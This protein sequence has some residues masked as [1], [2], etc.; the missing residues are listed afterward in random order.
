MSIR[1]IAGAAVHDLP[2][3]VR[4]MLGHRWLEMRNR[5]ERVTID[6]RGVRCEWEFTSE[7]HLANVFPS[8][9]ARLMRAAFEQWPIVMSSEPPTTSDHPEV[10]FVIGHRGTERLP[11]LLT[12]LRSI[13]GQRSAS[14]ECIVIEQDRLP[15]IES[16]LPKWVRYRFVECETDYNRAATLNAGVAESRAPIVVLHDNDML[17]PSRY[18]AECVAR[19]SEG[20]DFL[21]LKRFTFYLPQK[22]SERVFA[23]GSIRTNVPSTII[24]NLLGAS[25]AVRRSAYEAAGG[26]D[27]EFVGWG[28]E[29]NEFWERAEA[30]GKVYRFGYLPFLHLFH[31]PQKGKL[32]PNA[33][34][35]RRYY[36]IRNVPP[37][38]RIQR[39]RNR[40]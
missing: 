1:T 12:T 32:D 3:F 6:N 40:S 13:A 29:D 8:L 10:A 18:A 21:E 26:F 38:E 20:F 27:E 30:S 39:L 19:A 22:E 36:D 4:A 37:A 35:V 28:G 34:A 14:I 2:R 7:L 9:G 33:P 11:H 5:H 24:Q 23:G 17:V 25:I 31:A 15:R 16:A